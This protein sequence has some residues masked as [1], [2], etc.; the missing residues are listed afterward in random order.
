MKATVYIKSHYGEVDLDICEFMDN[1][2]KSRNEEDIESVGCA[3]VRF[4]EFLKAI[5]DQVYSEMSESHRTLIVNGLQ[6]QIE[7]IKKGGE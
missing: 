6:Y 4:R 2:L 1:F 7:R 3:I 5:P